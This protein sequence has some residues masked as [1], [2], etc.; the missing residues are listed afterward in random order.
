MIVINRSCDVL[1][2]F[3]VMR[4]RAEGEGIRFELEDALE[5]LPGKLTYIIDYSRNVDEN[6]FLAPEMTL[7]PISVAAVLI[8]SAADLVGDDFPLED[9]PLARGAKLARLV[10]RVSG[11]A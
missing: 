6:N 8:V 2:R 4:E 11:D 1:I 9:F 5:S 10:R 3:V 7:A